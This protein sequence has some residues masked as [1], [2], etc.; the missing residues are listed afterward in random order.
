MMNCAMR[1]S[2]L[3][4][5]LLS[6]LTLTSAAPALAQAP[7]ATPQSA[8]PAA[9]TAGQPYHP[10]RFFVDIVGKGPDVI[11]IPGL[12]SSRDVWKDEAA[13]LAPHYRLFLVQIYGF[14]GYKPGPNASGPLLQ[15]ITDELAQYI[16]SNHLQQPAVIGHSLGGLIGLMLASQH[17]SD[18][19]KLMVVDALPFLGL[20]DDSKN[21]VE[22]VHDAAVEEK[23]DLINQPANIFIR[24]ENLQIANLVTSPDNRKLV[25]FWTANSDR[26]V[27]AD[28]VYDDMTTDV[29]P[30]L[31]K[32]TA[33]VTVLYAGGSKDTDKLY[34]AAYAGT[35]HLKLVKVDDTLHFIMLDQPKKFDEAVEEFLKR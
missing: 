20:L 27:L 21:T 13:K 6:A 34:T 9:T 30:Q 29:R 24:S 7:A 23:S 33:P 15:P 22:H 5:T 35:P 28:A 3:S 14:A 17:P 8:P 4:L 10:T 1:L 2:L 19:G 18:V 12:G 26:R 32:I 11:L 25:L 31:A 16:E